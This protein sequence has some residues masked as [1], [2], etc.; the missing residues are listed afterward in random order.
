MKLSAYPLYRKSSD[1][2][3]NSTGMVYPGEF[4]FREKVIIMDLTIIYVTNINYS[5]IY[6]VNVLVYSKTFERCIKP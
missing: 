5:V 4:F 6:C 3:E 2:G 1:S